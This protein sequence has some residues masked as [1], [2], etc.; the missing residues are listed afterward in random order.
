[1]SNPRCCGAESV[2]VENVPGK[3]YNFC[4]KCKQ[5]VGDSNSFELSPA[6]VTMLD[7]GARV[8]QGF[9]SEGLIEQLKADIDANTGCLP[10]GSSVKASKIEV[11]RDQFLKEYEGEWRGP[12]IAKR[13][14]IEDLRSYQCGDPSCPCMMSASEAVQYLDEQGTNFGPRNC[15]CSAC[16][17]DFEMDE[18]CDA[19]LVSRTVPAGLYL[20]MILN[21]EIAVAP[22]EE[23]PETPLPPDMTWVQTSFKGYFQGHCLT[24]LMVVPV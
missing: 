11:F 23:I 10:I 13:R 16:E 19:P 22:I 2:W 8:P 15:N 4:R 21:N 3:G 9:W 20:V 14:D 5:E 6:D 1:M 18:A 24:N 17:V 7:S 12:P